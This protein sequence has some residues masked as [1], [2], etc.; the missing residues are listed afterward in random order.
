MARRGPKLKFQNVEELKAKTEQYFK[1]CDPHIVEVEDIITKRDDEGRVIYQ[2]VQ[3]VQELS[4]QRPYTITGLALA[5]GTTRNV[6]LDY[7]NA[8]HYAEDIGEELLEQIRHTIKDAKE[9]C[10][11]FA[12]E[13]LFANNPTGVIFN[14]KNNYS[15]WVDR[16][17]VEQTNRN[18]SDVLDELESEND[19]ANKAKEAY[20]NAIREERPEAEKQVVETNQPVQDQGQ[21]GQVSDVPAE[22]NTN[23]APQ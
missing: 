22:P 8:E 2:E 14:L 23:Q 18:I 21:A 15:G 3:K 4:K 10:H 19:V 13:R 16:Q 6:L 20:D 17:E 12:E 1:D 11:N 7:E 5:L 9:K